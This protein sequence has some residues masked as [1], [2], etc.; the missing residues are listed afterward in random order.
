VPDIGHRTSLKNGDN[1]NRVCPIAA[2]AAHWTDNKHV[3]VI[4]E[5]LT[6]DIK[7]VELNC[8]LDESCII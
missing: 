4:A 2:I 5:Q 8:C 7:A 6:N 1:E 3:N